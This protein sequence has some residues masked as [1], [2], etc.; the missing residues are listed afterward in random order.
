MPQLAPAPWQCRCGM[1]SLYRTTV[2][3]G[4]FML[5]LGR[6]YGALLSHQSPHFRCARAH[7]IWPIAHSL[8]HHR[9][10]AGH[11]H[12]PPFLSSAGDGTLSVITASAGCH[13]S[14]SCTICLWP[15]FEATWRVLPCRQIVDVLT[16]ADGVHSCC[17]R[18]TFAMRSDLGQSYLVFAILRHGSPNGRLS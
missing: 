8:P 13:G 7:G 18:P 10:R 4:L 3:M 16:G 14:K 1:K 11:V 12:K 5:L 9:P 17:P 15:S 2:H 6:G